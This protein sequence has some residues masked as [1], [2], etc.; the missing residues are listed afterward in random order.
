MKTYT[1]EEVAKLLN[2]DKETVRRWLRDKKKSGLSTEM[3][4]K[5]EGYVITE[6]TLDALLSSHP[7]YTAIATTSMIS[8]L[9]AGGVLLST[10][11]LIDTV[12]K[13]LQNDNPQI[14]PILLRQFIEK[15]MKESK[16][17]IR[18]RKEEIKKLQEAVT[19]EEQKISDLMNLI[20]L[21][22]GEEEKQ[23]EA[24]DKLA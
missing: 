24:T 23:K 21:L 5:K 11:L 17:R 4:S 7:K 2:I 16:N 8:G 6:A 19:E 14:S 9:L 10:A 18:K 20:E 12:K 1:V 22:P 15:E 3:K 13:N